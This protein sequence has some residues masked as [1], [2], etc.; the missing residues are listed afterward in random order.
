VVEADPV[1]TLLREMM[2]ERGTR[3]GKASDLLE[4]RLGEKNASNPTYHSAVLALW[5]PDCGA[6]RPS[7]E[8]AGIEIA[9]SREG[10]PGA[11]MIRMGAGPGGL[12]EP[13]VIV[14]ASAANNI[15]AGRRP[16]RGTLALSTRWRSGLLECAGARPA[17]AAV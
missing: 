3:A 9:F 15:L 2:A 14:A 13:W 10:R 8:S 6:A 4:A 1:A 16:C 17:P 7:C 12:A 11:R 5:P